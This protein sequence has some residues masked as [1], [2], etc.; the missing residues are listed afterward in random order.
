LSAR[1]PGPVRLEGE[2][3][4]RN[5]FSYH[6]FDVEVARAEG[7]W[8]HDTKG[9]AYI[10]ASGGPMAV[11]L[12][13]GDARVIDAIKRQLDAFAYVHPTLANRPRADL[14]DAIASVTPEGFNASYLVSGGSEAVETALKIA[15]QYHVATG[16]PGKHKIISFRESY[17]GMTLATM[18]LSGNPGT[19]TIFDPM[20]PKWPKTQQYSEFR[21]PSHLSPEEWAADCA[22]ELERLVHYEGPSTIAA[23]IATPHGCGSEYGV[24]APASY[25]RRIR[26]ICTAYDILFIADEVVS[27]FGR[28]GAWFAMEHFGVTP[29]IITMAKGIASCYAPLGAVS[30]SDR[31]NRPFEEGAGFIHGFTYGGHPLACAAGIAVINAIKED[32][33]VEGARRKSERLF[34]Q[35]ER[36]LAHETVADVRG[37]GLF[38]VLEL[39]EDKAS[40]A[41]F[42][43]NRQAET[44]F[45]SIALTNGL[46]L[47]STLYGPRRAGVARRGLPMWISPPLTISEEE[48]DVLLD[49]LD[50]TIGEW[51]R[52]L[53]VGA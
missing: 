21:R 26:E 43:P 1:D 52:E 9:R 18:A 34:A 8:I 27:G 14:C 36:L 49:R 15:R 47:Y 53:G 46:A 31:V 23:F 41:Y 4:W 51:E 35:R 28:T 17:H 3:D 38:M 24:V 16:A 40:R 50:R 44:L 22:D 6:A 32:G 12:G 42:G 33:L 10:D 2:T 7:V 48:I 19:A 45:Q 29:D 37:W 5:A 39:V 25:W 13:H 30:V 20:L 11:N